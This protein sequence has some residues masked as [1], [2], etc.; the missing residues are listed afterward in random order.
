LR[1]SGRAANVSGT[2][3]LQ[4]GYPMTHLTRRA[5]TFGLAALSTGLATLPARAATHQVTIKGFAFDPANLSIAKGDT[6][7][8]TN[9]DSAPHTATG[10]SFDTGTLKKGASA[11]LTFATAGTFDYHCNFHGSMKG[12]ITVA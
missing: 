12:K 7:E 11:A 5:A 9:A 4:K 1:D 3:I 8:F 6:V 10:K 2:K